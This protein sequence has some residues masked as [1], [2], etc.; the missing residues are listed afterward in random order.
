METFPSIEMPHSTDA[1]MPTSAP[2]RLQNRVRFRRREIKALAEDSLGQRLAKRRLALGLTQS[3]VAASVMIEPKTGA[4]RG[5]SRPISRNAYC[6]YE[7]DMIEPSLTTV[8]AMAAILQASPA[9]LAFGARNRLSQ[10]RSPGQ[11]RPPVAP[12]LVGPASP[13]PSLMPSFIQT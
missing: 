7:L 10:G 11:G 3:E 13:S 5:V 8:R 2:R 12:S 4:N 9:W 6:M 1:D